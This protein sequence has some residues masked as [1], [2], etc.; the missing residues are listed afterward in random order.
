METL[1]LID[2]F[3]SHAPSSSWFN[4]PKKFVWER[5]VSSHETIVIT[6]LPLVESLN[7]KKIYGWLIESPLVTPH[8]YEYAKKNHSKFEGIFTFDVELLN[9]SEKFI[10]LPIGGCWVEQEKRKVSGKDKLVSMVYS[11]KKKLDGHLLRHEI[12]SRFNNIDFY[13]SGS[14][15]IDK[16]SSAIEKY[17]FSI[18]VENCK[19]DF[20]FSEKIIDCFVMGTIPI[21]WGCPSIGNFFNEKGIITFDNIDELSSILSTID[22]KMYLEKKEF[23][24]ENYK[25]SKK[26]LVADDIIYKKIKYG[27]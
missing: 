19:K 16:K 21:Y 13:G 7:N 4:L 25:K 11:N 10:F 17:M 24:L 27:K 1:A 6:N 23:V 2:N 9:L 12:A 15:P 14:N 20:Y 3:F 26:Y 8:H 5:E 18:V 22:E